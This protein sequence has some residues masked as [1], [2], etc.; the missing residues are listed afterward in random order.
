MLDECGFVSCQNGSYRFVVAEYEA[1]RNLVFDALN[2]MPGVVL[3]RP[4]G[5][6]YLCARLP[7]DDANGF[8]EFLLRDFAVDNETVMLAPA[9]GFYATPGAG[10]HEVRIAYVLNLAE[11]GRAMNVI[12]EALAAYPGTG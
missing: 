6:F 9:D 5:A 10:R 8:A 11:L 4:E 3:R 7:V 1:R 12:R 2:S